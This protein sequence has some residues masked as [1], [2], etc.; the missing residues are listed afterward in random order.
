MTR[1]C[2]SRCPSPP[3]ASSGCGWAVA[4][5]RRP[6]WATIASLGAILVLNGTY[7]INP[8]GG[9][10]LAGRFMWTLIPAAVAWSAVVVARWE[11]AGRLLWAPALLIVGFW[12]YEAVPLVADAHNYFNV[13]TELHVWDPL[14]VTGW[15][16]GLDRVL[17]TFDLPGTTFGSP[18]TGLAF[19]LGVLVLVAIAAVEYGRPGRFAKG[20][21]GRDGGARRA[22][23]D[24]RGRVRTRP[25][26]RRL[27]A[28]RR[29][30]RRPDPGRG[31][32]HVDPGLGPPA[33]PAGHVPHHD[34]LPPDRARPDRPGTAVCCSSARRH[35]ARSPARRR[36]VYP[37][38]P[39][40][41][42]V[43]ITC[44]ATARS[45]HSSPSPPTPGST[46]TASGCA[47]RRP[48]RPGPRKGGRATVRAGLM[49][50]GGA[51]PT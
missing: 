30:H 18:S 29:A 3:S 33:R 7:T 35:A 19:E 13:F 38:T 10:S 15:W 37:P 21:D 17:P 45:S 42:S 41:R 9:G 25:A 43:G 50:S 2:S 27:L 36:P 16:P 24:R 47:R 34:G 11:R 31:D 40:S 6:P 4:G 14:D 22:A 8:Y 44:R 26:R 51:A 20:L 46:S 1:A 39:G 5:C 49:P 32:S 23:R 48:E 28:R 12:L